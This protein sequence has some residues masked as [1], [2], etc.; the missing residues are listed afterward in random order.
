ME[1]AMDKAGRIVIPK[2]VR[3]KLHLQPGDEFE[4]S[5][6]NTGFTLTPVRPRARMLNRNGVWVRTTGKPSTYD[7][8][9]EV[10]K[11]REER[12]EQILGQLR[13]ERHS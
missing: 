3:E 2:S 12:S 11:S 8:A 9:A 4:I 10:E 13:T 1:V 5:D 7:P 6:V